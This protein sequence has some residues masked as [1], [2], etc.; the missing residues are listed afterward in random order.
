MLIAIFCANFTQVSC[1]HTKPHQLASEHR[2]L[3]PFQFASSRQSMDNLKAINS[4]PAFNRNNLNI[5]IHRRSEIAHFDS[6]LHSKHH[7]MT[8]PMGNLPLQ[9]AHKSSGKFSLKLNIP[10]LKGN[11]R[12]CT[13]S[14]APSER[15]SRNSFRRSRESRRRSPSNY[16]YL[17]EWI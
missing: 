2:Q 3:I 9:V 5:C 11:S 1:A 6:L 17:C 12:R 14:R 4:L 13:F 15:S 10:K 7:L 8:L 16:C